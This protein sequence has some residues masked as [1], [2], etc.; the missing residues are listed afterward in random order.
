MYLSRI[1]LLL[2]SVFYMYTVHPVSV[3]ARF[4][5]FGKGWGIYQF[6]VIFCLFTPCR[7]PAKGGAYSRKSTFLRARSSSSTWAKSSMKRWQTRDW[8]SAD[9]GARRTT[10]SWRSTRIS[11]LTVSE[12]VCVRA[13]CTGTHCGA[14]VWHRRYWCALIYRTEPCVCSNTR[15]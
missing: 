7:R 2:L 11:S 4:S 13:V 14:R 12:R 15:F 8:R 3:L 9:D 5:R 1:P 6:M 10:T